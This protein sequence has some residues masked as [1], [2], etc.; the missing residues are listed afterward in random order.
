[1]ELILANEKLND[2]RRIFDYEIDV[3]LGDTNTFE[4]K[5]SRSDY[6]SDLTFGNAIYTKGTEY[7]GIIGQIN[8]ET[9]L[10]TVNLKGYTWRGM[11]DKKIIKPTA[12]QSHRTISGELN[13]VLKTLINEQFNS[14]FSISEEDTGVSV[15]NF[16]FDRYCTLLSGIKKMLKSV[17]YKLDI[18]YIQQEQGLPGFVQLSATEIVDYSQAIELSNDDQ[19][20]FAFENVRNGVNHLICLGQGE[21]QDR[22]VVDLYVQQDGSIGTTP[23]LTGT[24]EITEIY[25]DTGA[26]DAAE[27][28]EKGTEKLLEKMNYTTFDMDVETLEI[29]VDIGDIIGGRD[30]DTGLYAKKPVSGKIWRVENGEQSIEY[31]VSGEGEESEEIA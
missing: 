7:G 22:T 10:D 15:T 13:T 9:S 31:S 5:V 17:G 11:L 19:L 24:K 29:D 8:T 27:L 25:E 21:L 2:I 14:V 20:N 26:G 12:G 30:Y 6:A 18:D 28:Q 4:F 23:Y 1:M 3:D 16:Q